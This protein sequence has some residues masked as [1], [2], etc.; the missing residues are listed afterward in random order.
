MLIDALL[1]LLHRVLRLP[2]ALYRS[3]RA[4]ALAGLGCL[5]L[6]A[7]AANVLA[8]YDLPQR[9]D[10]TDNRTYTLSAATLATLARINEPITLHF[11]YSLQLGEAVPAD[12]A[13][14]ARVRALLDQYVATVPGKLRLEASSLGPLSAAEEEAAVAAGLQPVPPGAAAADGVGFFGLV[15]TNSTDDRRVIARFDP[16]R[17]AL[18]EYDLTRL[19]YFLASPGAPASAAEADLA[20]LRQQRGAAPRP[21]TVIDRLQQQG[22]VRAAAERQTL[23][24]QIA[25]IQR[26][27]R[28]LSTADDG[29]SSSPERATATAAARLRVGLL[30]A[31]R[32]LLLVEAAAGRRATRLERVVECVD[33]AL[34]PIL[35]AG[36]AAALTVTRSIRRRRATG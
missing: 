23:E 18:L 34:A 8:A 19:F 3:G 29:N 24:Q 16:A 14:A 4:R 9:F 21:L 15:G 1:Y 33:I 7:V 10:V 5:A 13:Y 26:R 22:A 2:W 31:R 11:Y 12:T 36:A 6:L 32:R 28:D 20:G 35:V 25:E 30:A 27:L 17:E